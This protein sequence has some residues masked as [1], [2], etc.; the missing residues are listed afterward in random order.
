MVVCTKRALAGDIFAA[1]T[2]VEY[3]E[4]VTRDVKRYRYW[5]RVV[6]RLQKAHLR[7][8]MRQGQ[9]MRMRSAS[10]I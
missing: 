1:K 8:Q 2:M 10:V 9:G 7:E 5:L 4:M 6:A 3:H